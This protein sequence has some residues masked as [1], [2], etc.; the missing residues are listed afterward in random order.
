MNPNAVWL[1]QQCLTVKQSRDEA[2][3]LANQTLHII[4]SA[5]I[6]DGEFSDDSFRIRV[7]FALFK[8]SKDGTFPHAVIGRMVELFEDGGLTVESLSA[9][10]ADAQVEDDD[11]HAE[12]DDMQEE[13][14]DDDDMQEV[15][16]ENDNVV[17]ESSLSEEKV[18]STEKSSAMN[19]AENEDDDM[20]EGDLQSQSPIAAD[21]VSSD[22]KDTKPDKKKPIKTA[23]TTTDY[24]DQ[25]IDSNEL[26]RFQ[27]RTKVLGLAIPTF[28]TELWRYLQMAGWTYVSGTYR[29]PKDKRGEYSDSLAL[30]QRI[31]RLVGDY[32]NITTKLLQQQEESDAE[33]GPESFSSANDIV[34]YL[35]Q[36]CLPDHNLTPSQIQQ[37]REKLAIHSKAYERRCKRLR[38]ELLEIAFRERTRERG[39]Y[40]EKDGCLKSMYGHN[41]RPCEVCFEG[42]SPLYPR[43]A[44]RDCGLVV[45]TDCYG[46]SVGGKGGAKGSRAVDPKG[47]FQCEVCQVG[48][49]AGSI[50]KK[51]LWNAPQ[52][53]RWREYSHPA[54][55]CQL[56]DY[57]FI[58][59]GMI[60]LKSE[61]AS[62]KTSGAK[63]RRSRDSQEAWVHIYCYSSLTGK[64]YEHMS[65][66]TEEVVQNIGKVASSTHNNCSYC[67]KD[68]GWTM[69]CDK[70]CGNYFHPTC[71]QLELAKSEIVAGKV[72]VCAQCYTKSEP[73]KSD[74]PVDLGLQREEVS[75]QLSLHQPV[76]STKADHY[77]YFKL[78]QKKKKKQGNDVVQPKETIVVPPIQNSIA[79]A[80][81]IHDAEQAG[82]GF[83]NYESQYNNQF[84][85]WSFSLSTGHSILMYG[86]GSKRDV[87]ESFG[88]ALA[89]EGNVISI[90]GYDAAM[91]LTELFD[92][93]IQI[94]TSEEESTP[95]DEPDVSVNQT[96]VR[97]EWVKKAAFV[98]E[99]YSDDRPL[100][101][102]IHN[103]DGEKLSSLCA[104]E[105]LA[106]LTKASKRNGQPNIRIVASIDD[107]N[108]S[109]FWDPTIEHK[110]NWSWKSV[111]TYRPHF[112]EI[113]KAP[114]E[115][116]EKKTKK[117]HREKTFASVK[118]VLTS[119]A[120]KHKEII[121]LLA[122]M[123]SR[124]PIVTYVELREA[125]ARSLI[126]AQ[127]S[128]IRPILRELRDHSIVQHGTTGEG[129]D[130]KEVVFIPTN[131]MMNEILQFGVNGS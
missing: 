37:D 70:K 40:I 77:Q 22:Q 97:K 88:V 14:V 127:D 28:T 46:L 62:D 65:Q 82:M 85:D 23:A 7:Q 124:N 116:S 54:A 60:Q 121:M 1:Y 45:H 115:I 19:H 12:D 118:S 61:A 105:A 24:T 104:Q 76:K 89:A 107:V 66:N 94:V 36:Y 44:C 120:P 90:N 91:N 68:K 9:A 98:A 69:S 102:L 4:Q 131:E 111:N 38:Y 2:L 27:L 48:L 51:Q 15:V 39:T 13:I 96:E 20:E 47:Y 71:L 5:P 108:R 26:Y 83:S 8:I 18:A 58:A 73:G 67:T 109:M 114:K 103:I 17:E 72:N 56:C 101:L 53:A 10:A 57:Q 106:T 95:F 50:S 130:E 49:T 78:P 92:I 122:N 126:A 33:E 117:I 99:R 74:K 123:Q 112:D 64:A 55:I 100:F 11:A 35:D 52:S 43:V 84:R 3:N 110:F 63:R 125:C 87:L 93:L 29:P 34:D 21:K 75:P 41:H 86:L 30:A 119:L 32:A 113:E 81:K 25:T 80:R 42:S 59:G 128:I 79:E 31:F 16:D 129:R 6:E